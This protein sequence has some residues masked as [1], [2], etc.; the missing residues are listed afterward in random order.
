MKMFR[1][2]T[3]LDLGE[4][5][6]GVLA[7]MKL[8]NVYSRVVREDDIP[9]QAEDNCMSVEELL[10]HCKERWETMP[11][12]LNDGGRA[13]AGL[14]EYKSDCVNRA[15]AIANH[16]PY[17]DVRSGL[18]NIHQGEVED[19]MRELEGIDPVFASEVR[20]GR[21]DD[22]ERNDAAVVLHEVWFSSNLDNGC[23]PDLYEPY[24]ESRGW[25]YVDC[26]GKN[27][28][29]RAGDLPMGRLVVS[30]PEHYVAVIDGVIHDTFDPSEDGTAIIDGYW[31]L[32]TKEV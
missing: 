32:P 21:S 20:C 17:L 8:P 5:P 1:I 22:P 10:S 29:L 26:K 31:I 3:P 6:E 11:F 16:L 2:E 23:A 7:M 27:T 15:I 24:L 28:R 12:S 25:V 30:I 14:G 9:Q 19:Q 4:L 18:T 13:G